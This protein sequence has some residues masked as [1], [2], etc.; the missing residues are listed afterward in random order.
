MQSKINS[1]FEHSSSSM[2]KNAVPSQCGDM[3]DYE[4]IQPEIVVTYQRR[5]QN[6][7][8][9]TDGASTG[10]ASKEI[11]LENFVP[12]GGM[13]KSEKVLNKK[14]KFAQFYC[15]SDFLLHTCTVCGFKYARG[16]E[17]DKSFIRC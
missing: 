11:H 3:F 7:I 12:N 6:R 4:M 16:Y 13:A 8:G 1:F 10:E 14:R 15:Q 9:E 2:P 5:P 17:G